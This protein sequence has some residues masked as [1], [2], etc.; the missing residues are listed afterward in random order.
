MTQ[1]ADAPYIQEAERLGMPPYGDQPDHD[2]EI[3]FLEEIRSR[4]EAIDDLL[5]DTEDKLTGTE[6]EDQPRELMREFDALGIK[7]YR[8]IQDLR[9]E[10]R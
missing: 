4:M 6:Y 3:T 1:I 5:L 8:L 10:G 9:K 7:V 2:A